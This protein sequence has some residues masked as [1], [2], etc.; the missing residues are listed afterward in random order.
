[1]N[2]KCDNCQREYTFKYKLLNMF[3]KKIKFTCFC[4]DV[5]ELAV[6]HG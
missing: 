5:K 3:G 1:M 2:Y 6:N 4:Q